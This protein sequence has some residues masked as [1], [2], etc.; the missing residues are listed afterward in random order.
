M[1]ERFE[2]N[3]MRQQV[4]ITILK[5]DVDKEIGGQVARACPRGIIRRTS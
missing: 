4:K 5:T 1:N 2:R 3:T